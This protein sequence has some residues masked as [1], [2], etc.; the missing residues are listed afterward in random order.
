MYFQIKINKMIYSNLTI[1]NIILKIHF[2]KAKNQDVKNIVNVV[3][4]VL[5][6]SAIQKL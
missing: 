1:N 5:T 6:K 4:N 2:L 3:K